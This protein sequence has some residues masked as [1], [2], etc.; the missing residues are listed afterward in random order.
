MT[1]WRTMFILA[2]SIIIL[3]P[4]TS[5]ATDVSGGIYEN[6]TWTLD[7]SPYHVVGDVTLFPGYTLTIEPGVEVRSDQNKKLAIRGTLTA[8]GTESQRIVFSAQ[9][10][11]Q[12]WA[13][14]SIAAN[15]GGSGRFAYADLSY[16]ANAINLECCWGPN[17]PATVDHCTFRNNSRGLNGYTGYYIPVTNSTFTDNFAGSAA[18]NVNFT[19]CSFTQNIF[20][21]YNVG[22]TYVRNCAISNNGTGA[23]GDGLLDHCTISGNNL[24]VHDSFDG[25]E[26]HFNVVTGNRIGIRL[27]SFSAYPKDV[28]YNDIFGNTDSSVVNPQSI[29]VSAPNNWW[30]TTDTELIDASIYDGRDNVGLGLVLYLPIAEEPNVGNSTPV[31]PATWGGIKAL[32]AR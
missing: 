3:T 23:F 18:G 9:T 14:I 25:F 15:Q 28:S 27:P 22:S 12:L 5:R 4:H 10:P 11:P 21:L 19:D 1:A 7:S 32:Y 16:A 30:G 8:T 29:N 24:G 2:L 31:Q 26:M 13:G 17:P 20:G 6:T